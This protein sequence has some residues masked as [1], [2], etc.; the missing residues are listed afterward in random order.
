MWRGSRRAKNSTAA[1]APVARAVTTRGKL[2]KSKVAVRRRKVRMLQG[3]L[4]LVALVSLVG[5]LSWASF[6]NALTID[7]ILVEGNTHI[8]SRAIETHVLNA[9]AG[10]AWGLFSR[11]NSL[12]YPRDTLEESL[13]VAFPK[14]ETVKL[15]TKPSHQEV[16]VAIQERTTYALWCRSALEDECYYITDTGFVFEPVE[17]NRG[18]STPPYIVFTGGVTHVNDSVV[19]QWVA[20][21]TFTDVV[22]LLQELKER[23]VDVTSVAFLRNDAVLHAREGWELRVALD[24]DLRA[25]AVNLSAVLDEYDLRNRLTDLQ[26]IDMRFDERVYYKVRDTADSSE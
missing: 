19:R 17:E 22:Q 5:F 9:T 6:L 8:R 3:A 10:A 15:T 2:G 11:Q 18:T 12:T 13:L 1:K 23:N 24:K 21:D 14:I 25:T 20:Q 7:T 26:Y 4:A 16:R